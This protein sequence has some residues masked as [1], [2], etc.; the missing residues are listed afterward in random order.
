[1]IGAAIALLA[2][3][4]LLTAAVDA[5]WLHKVPTK[6]RT[7][8]NPYAGKPEAIAAGRVLFEE[9]CA[10]CH[11]EDAQ[12]KHGRPSLRSNVVRNAT[13]GDLAWL[14]RNGYAWK[15]MPSWSSLPEQQRWQIIAYLR[16]LPPEPRRDAGGNGR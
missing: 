15:G 11:G 13:D 16:S 12:G 9:N 6:E 10:K 7:R 1:M 14:L 2:C 8:V 4:T 5:S 3:S